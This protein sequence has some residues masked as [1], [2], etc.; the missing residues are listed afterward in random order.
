M[1]KEKHQP[2]NNF[3]LKFGFLSNQ[4]VSPCFIVEA[5]KVVE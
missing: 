2:D 1:G 5:E 4:G 3:G